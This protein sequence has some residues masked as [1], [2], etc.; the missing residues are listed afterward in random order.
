MEIALD[1]A[2]PTFSGGLGMLAGDML[3]SAADL[4]LPMVGVSLLYRHGYFEQSLDAYGQQRE[5]PTEWNPEGK[6]DAINA[7]AALRIEGR[8]VHVRAWRYL[9]HGHAGG[10]VPVYLLDTDLPEN[11]P[12]TAVCATGYTVETAA[13]GFARKRF[14]GWAACGC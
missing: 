14:W 13:T 2:I 12:G 5:T 7:T 4:N 11:D 1:N 9:V 10:S 8:T 6:L 3:R